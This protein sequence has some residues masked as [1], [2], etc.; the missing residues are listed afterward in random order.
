MRPWKENLKALGSG[1]AL[2]LAFTLPWA[3]YT[4]ACLHTGSSVAAGG[5]AELTQGEDEA[6]L[7]ALTFDDGPS[8]ATTPALLDGLA[9][10]GV[11]ATFF[12]VGSMAADN[13]DLVR[14]MSDEGHQIGVHTYDHSLSKGLTGLS[15]AQFRAQ[16]DATRDLLTALTGQ[17]QYALRPPYGFVD[18]SV[19]RWAEGPIIL[20]SVDPEDWKDQNARRV[21]QHILSHAEDGSIVLLHDI[22][23]S[24]VDAALQVVDA[25]MEQ[26]YR[27]VT[28][29][30]LFAAR[31][32]TPAAGEVYNGLGPQDV[33]P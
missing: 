25:L 12:L 10:R 26:G 13:H 6:P 14:R 21:V 20:W 5:T 9:R 29:D 1:L 19:R 28:V 31:G 3:A 27:F 15:E 18:D 2:L 11:H 17:T 23:S 7:I 8:S 32:L 22:F 4:A 24:S 33:L 16:V 30:E